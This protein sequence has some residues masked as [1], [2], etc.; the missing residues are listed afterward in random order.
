MAGFLQDAPTRWFTI[1]AHRPFV[2]DLAA[3]LL[4]MLAP[5]GPEA[6]ADAT[7]L[8]PTRRGARTLAEAFVKAGGGRAVLLPQIRA[9]GDLDEG[10]PPF[11]PGELALTLP[12]AVSP[13]RRRFELAR[14]VHDNASRL[15]F[16]RA[17]DAPACLELADA[18]AAFLDS[19]QIEEIVDPPLDG[20]V[21]G[22]LAKH[23]RLSAEVLKIAVVDWPKRLRSLGLIDV[24]ERRALLL[25]TLATQWKDRP[26]A[27]V[28]VAAGSTGTAKGAADLLAAVAAAPQGCVVLPGLDTDLA[29]EAWEDIDE[30]HPQA[31]LKRLLDRHGV[32]RG[33]VAEWPSPEGVGDRLRGRSRRRVINEALRPAEAT[34]DWRAQIDKLRAEGASSGIDPIAEGLVGLSVVRA[35]AEEEAAAIAALALREALEVP[36]RTAALVTPD[37]NLARRVSARLSRWGIAADSSAGL[38]LAQTPVGVLIGLLAEA[39]AEAPNPVRLLGIVK[40]PLVRLGRD[41]E[42]LSSARRDLERYGLRGPRPRGWDGLFA[43]LK[44]LSAHP[45]ESRDPGFLP[46]SDAPPEDNKNAWVPAFA[47]MSGESGAV[48]LAQDLKAALDLAAAPFVLGSVSPDDAARALIDALEA[49]ARGPDGDAGGLWANAAGESAASLLAGV[50]EEGSALPPATASGFAAIAGRLL[51]AQP[52][53]TGGAAHPRLRILGALEARLVGADTLVLAGLEEGVWPGSPAA[54][55]F[56]S[57]LMRERLGLPPLERRIGLTAHD[58]AQA[59]C[60]PQVV[61]IH[62]DRRGGQPAVMSRWLW[63]LETLA[64]G[65]AVEL[66]RRPE[67]AAWAR[68]LDAPI[69]SPP[70]S[71]KP[72]ERPR[73]KPPVEARPRVLPVTGVEMWVRDPYGVYARYVLRLRNLERPDEPVEARARG[74]AIH[75]AFEQF[76]RDHPEVMPAEAET[77]F[78]RMLMEHLEA[79]GMPEPAM[80]R[81]RTLAE[82]AAGWAM[83]FERDRRP[84]ARLLVEQRGELTFD[85]LFAPFTVTARADRIEVCSGR[86]DVLDFKTGAP[87][88]PKQVEAGFAPQ[89]TL[90]AAI[91]RGGGFTEAGA[92]MP[93]ELLYVRVIG[94][95]VA[96]ELKHAVDMD[97]ATAAEA[98]LNG[99]KLRVERFDN[100]ET[101]YLAWAAPQF[102]SQ[103]GGDYDHLSR[104]YEWHVMGGGDGEGGE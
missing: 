23:W 82:R 79:E 85:G 71:L 35:A 81:E 76:V 32:A 56:L 5:G 60:A 53:R 73:P 4:Q 65:A 25:R 99:L 6:L 3:G 62:A 15:P 57:R 37:A 67:L 14:L 101:P 75:A 7:V 68:A 8:T 40:H 16:E 59:A 66:P 31:A 93:G 51:A 13:L 1:P 102:L 41:P 84:G 34:A 36:G 50:A 9:L 98:A 97:S 54:D 26:P 63:R 21:E 55:P 61:M 89:L 17:P 46:A 43:R 12:P 83:D 38:P 95:R 70:P 48:G 72:A 96:G 29:D 104:L 74:T 91:L 86:A 39:T 20:L 28:T 52:V 42:R 49:L 78:A 10:E 103:W 69:E 94:R 33:E 45:G 11:E 80:A 47:G 92:T 24:S 30:A 18:L 2:D 19:L 100:P 58:F 64:R 44:K 87:P 22:D 90:T 77:V 88:T 27:G